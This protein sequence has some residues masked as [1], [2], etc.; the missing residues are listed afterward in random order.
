MATIKTKDIKNMSKEDIEKTMK[1][2]KLELIRSKITSS[3][4]SRK[5]KEIKKIIARILTLTK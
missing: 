4:G 1:D 3:K 2:L 5:S